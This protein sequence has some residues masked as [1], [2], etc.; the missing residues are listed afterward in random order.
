MNIFWKI[1][2]IYTQMNPKG[3]KIITKSK[4]S[5]KIFIKII[6]IYINNK[7]KLIIFYKII[8]DHQKIIT[9]K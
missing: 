8:F 3:A 1:Y 2:I 6:K 7:I 5:L 9:V 4:I